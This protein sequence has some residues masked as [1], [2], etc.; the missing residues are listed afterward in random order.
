MER[1]TK[2]YSIQYRNGSMA[3]L[4]VHTPTPDELQKPAFRRS[5]PVVSYG[6][7]PTELASCQVTDG[8]ASDTFLS[9][10]TQYGHL[11]H[12][13]EKTPE[14]YTS[15][16]VEILNPKPETNNPAV[17]SKDSILCKIKMSEGEGEGEGEA[18]FCL[19]EG[20]GEALYGHDLHSLTECELLK[21]VD[22]FR[23]GGTMIVVT[24]CG[25]LHIPGP[26]EE[27]ENPEW[28]I[29]H[30]INLETL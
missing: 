9:V 30:E 29:H 20:Y 8:Y 14:W 7:L 15:H 13:F 12:E 4:R 2:N 28:S 22:I 3:Y 27:D 24:E 21:P 23:D 6:R 16:A 26:W 10:Q 1:A 19:L 11:M 25:N 17:G 5:P 18:Y